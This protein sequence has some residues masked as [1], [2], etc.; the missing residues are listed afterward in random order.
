MKKSQAYALI[1]LS[2]F[3]FGTSGIFVRLLSPYGFTSMQMTAMRGVISAVAL[4]LFVL[5]TKRQLFKT[6]WKSLLLFVLSGVFMFV[7]AFFYYTSMEH[8]TIATAVVLMYSAPI[9][10]LLFSVLFLKEK[11]TVTKVVAVAMMLVGMALVSGIVGGMDF[12]FWGVFFAVAAGVTYAAYNIVAKIE[13]KHDN[14]PL[15]AM[16]YCYITMGL[17]S[18]LCADVPQMVDL[19]VQGPPTL[20]LMIVGIGLCTCAVPYLI[21]TMTLKYIP[22]GTAS[23]LSLIEPMAAILYSIVFFQEQPTLPAIAGIVL[24]LGAVFLIGRIKE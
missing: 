12:N 6:N 22:A 21:Y 4:S 23:A 24:I 16:I 2:S 11:L 3:M 19:T 14:D 18:A 10:V 15:T 17:L 20:W 1:V 9:Y 5:F 13:M 8:T 7:T